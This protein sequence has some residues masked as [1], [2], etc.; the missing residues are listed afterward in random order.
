SLRAVHVY[1]PDPWW[2]QRHKKR[3]VFADSLIADIERTLKPGGELRIASDVEEYFGVITT[4]VSGRGRFLAQ[5]VSEPE[6]PEHA[7]D[8]PTNFERNYRIQG[9]SLFR[10]SYQLI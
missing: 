10:A 1:F 8:Y 7:L 5:I 6:A 4:L 3:R 2:K 9:R